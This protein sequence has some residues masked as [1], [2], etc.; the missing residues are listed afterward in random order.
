MKGG[1]HI[2]NVKW[3]YHQN[4][5]P[6]PFQFSIVLLSGAALKPNRSNGIGLHFSSLMIKT[7]EVGITRCLDAWVYGG[8]T[9][10]SIADYPIVLSIIQLQTAQLFQQL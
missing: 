2:L 7:R 3:V 4:S 5:S 10:D 8:A 1:L 9:M 6:L